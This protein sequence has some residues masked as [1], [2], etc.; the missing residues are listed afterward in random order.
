MV[1][2]IVNVLH[3][4]SAIVCGAP[5][6][7]SGVTLDPFCSTIVGSEILYQCQPGLLRRALLC[8]GD[9]RWN[10]DPRD[11]C[12]G[13]Y[14]WPI[15]FI[16]LYI[17]PPQKIACPKISF[18]VY[19]HCYRIILGVSTN[20]T[21]SFVLCCHK[22]NIAWSTSKVYVHTHTT[23]ILFT[24]YRTGII[25]CCSNVEHSLESPIY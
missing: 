2:A 10:P 15:F 12:T 11:L 21:G 23:K 18:I 3:A 25:A 8:G 24:D 5:T 22:L 1:D 19:K 6:F 9:G 4:A 14:K 20:I 7:A 16:L 17:T 13:I